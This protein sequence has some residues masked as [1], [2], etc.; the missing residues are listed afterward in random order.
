MKADP[1]NV[2]LLLLSLLLFLLLYCVY[3][4]VGSVYVVGDVDNCI[5]LRDVAVVVIAAAEIMK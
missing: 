3:Y 1:V 4:V 2:L 5:V